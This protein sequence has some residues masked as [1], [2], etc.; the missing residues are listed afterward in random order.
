[1][2]VVGI[3]LHFQQFEI[4]TIGSPGRTILKS[5]IVGAASHRLEILAVKERAKAARDSSYPRD[6]GP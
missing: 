1:M 3:P 6:G 4:G 5:S 2:R